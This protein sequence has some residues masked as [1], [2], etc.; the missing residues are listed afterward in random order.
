VSSA[1]IALRPQAVD[2]TLA[3]LQGVLDSWGARSAFVALW[4]QMAA[5]SLGTA[6]EAEVVVE[7]DPQ[8]RLLSFDAWVDGRRV[9]GADDWLG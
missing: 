7:F 8:A 5:G 1:R 9:Y 2:A 4:L 6:E 3:R